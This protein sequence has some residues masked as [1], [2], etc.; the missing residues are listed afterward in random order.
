MMDPDT[1][2][3]FYAWLESEFRLEDQHEVEQAIHEFLSGEPT[4]MDEGHTWWQALDAS[5]YQFGT[6]A[7][8]TMTDL[9]D[10]QGQGPHS[11]DVWDNQLRPAF[12]DYGTGQIY[13]SVFEDGSP[14]MVHY[15]DGLPPE[16]QQSNTLE[17]GFIDQSGTFYTR[18][19]AIDHITAEPSKEWNELMRNAG[20]CLT[21]KE[22]EAILAGYNPGDRLQISDKDAQT[23]EVQI[24]NWRKFTPKGNIYLAKDINT[25]EELYIDDNAREV[26]E[27]YLMD[28][29]YA[30]PQA[31]DDYIIP[32]LLAG[33]KF[34]ETEMKKICAVIEKESAQGLETFQLDMILS[35]LKNQIAPMAITVPAV[36]FAYIAL[37]KIIE[38]MRDK[39]AKAQEGEQEQYMFGFPATSEEEE[40]ALNGP[41]WGGGYTQ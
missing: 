37:K 25:G 39:S 15:I 34:T 19:E 16:A 3:H 31:E 23:R 13:P 27:E 5:G 35:I 41:G 11:F 36:M 7:A 26:G 14:A 24:K 30:E 28:Q 32:Y 29:S 1:A 17:S 40:D 2:E 8:Y 22:A 4:Y 20:R 12:R 38:S 21:R 18:E 33:S 9:Y 6:T 10:D